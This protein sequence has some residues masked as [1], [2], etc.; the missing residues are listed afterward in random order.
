[1]GDGINHRGPSRHDDEEEGSEELG[2]Q[3][4]PLISDIVGVA[5]PLGLGLVWAAGQ[6]GRVLERQFLSGKAHH[7]SHSAS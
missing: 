1:M 5:H 4:A 2:E 3:A 6:Y 7:I